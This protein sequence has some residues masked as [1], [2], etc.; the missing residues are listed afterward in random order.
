MAPL[1]S[2]QRAAAML[3][4]SAELVLTPPVD[5]NRLLPSSSS[6]WGTTGSSRGASTA[7][8]RAQG[9]D[10]VEQF[11]N[12]TQVQAWTRGAS[13]EHEIT[14]HADILQRPFLAVLADWAMDARQ[15]KSVVSIVSIC[16]QIM[17]NFV[18]LFPQ[19]FLNKREGWTRLQLQAFM[20][21][22]NNSSREFGFRLLTE[23]LKLR[24]LTEMLVSPGGDINSGNLVFSASDVAELQLSAIMDSD[25]KVKIQALVSVG[26]L[27]DKDW[28]SLVHMEVNVSQTPQTTYAMGLLHQVMERVHDPLGS[29]RTSACRVLGQVINNGGISAL[30]ISQGKSQPVVTFALGKIGTDG[31]QGMDID[32][33]SESSQNCGPDGPVLLSPTDLRSSKKF[34]PNRQSKLQDNTI[35][36]RYFLT[37]IT[38]SI[39]D[40]KLSV[41][42]Q[43]SYALGCCLLRLLPFRLQYLDK[44]FLPLP[45]P[46]QPTTVAVPATV[47]S[48][49]LGNFDSEELVFSGIVD[50]ESWLNCCRHAIS[51]LN[52]SDKILASAAR[53]LGLLAAGLLPGIEEHGTVLA[54]ILSQLLV[55]FISGRKVRSAQVA[56]TSTAAVGTLD[57][58]A[59]CQSSDGF[60]VEMDSAIRHNIVSLPKKVIFSLSLAFGLI[61]RVYLTHCVASAHKHN[62]LDYGFRSVSQPAEMN[63]IGEVQ[64]AFAAIL[65]HGLTSKIRL[66]SCKG[67]IF[68]Y[69]AGMAHPSSLNLTTSS[70]YNIFIRVFESVLLQSASFGKAKRL[71]TAQV[72]D[73][74]ITSAKELPGK[75]QRTLF[76]QRAV[77]VLS[78][79]M[80]KIAG[81]RAPSSTAASSVETRAQEAVEDMF[82]DQLLMVSSAQY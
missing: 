18:P 36:D 78:W 64:L 75:D 23:I 12:P 38:D 13:V 53:C 57:G 66:Q 25:P 9:S 49:H 10:D 2:F 22:K 35:V 32:G 77:L 21:S 63:K 27:N 79:V 45:L 1:L 40:S 76:L 4:P 14:E 69:F 26:E 47:S 42:L 82:T 20:S 33:Y 65:R 3:Y 54:D 55:K 19:L 61:S 28:L 31:G 52:D 17:L 60:A 24:K 11:G 43:G 74:P 58:T 16:K 70:S 34:S 48:A 41:R 50:D 39:H 46:P 68:L 59:S 67:L 73:G 7:W 62:D 72:S 56:G 37:L 6:S 15:E 29:I 30:C 44:R 71:R 80:L 51:Q 5:T 81:R 8:R